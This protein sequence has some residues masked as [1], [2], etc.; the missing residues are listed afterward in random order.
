MEARQTMPSSTM[1]KGYALRLSERINRSLRERTFESVL[2]DIELVIQGYRSAQIPERFTLEIL[3]DRVN[4]LE[5]LPEKGPVAQAI[6]HAEAVFLEAV[7]APHPTI[8][9]EQARREMTG[10]ET[11][12]EGPKSDSG[13]GFANSYSNSN[14]KA[15]PR[16][17]TEN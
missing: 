15:N 12:S 10:E 8:N 11:E 17:E 13:T 9:F 2:S 6:E 5:Q 1:P 3:H 16:D 7:V 4:A 14:T